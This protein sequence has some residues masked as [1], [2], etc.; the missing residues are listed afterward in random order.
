MILRT[1]ELL[2]HLVMI[3]KFCSDIIQLHCP[4][5]TQLIENKTPL[6]SDIIEKQTST[7]E[8]LYFIFFGVAKDKVKI[9]LCWFYEMSNTD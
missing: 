7:A 1:P 8:E 5:I 2:G 4:K 3:L 9:A 6:F